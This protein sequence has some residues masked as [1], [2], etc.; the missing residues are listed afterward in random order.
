MS[1]YANTVPVDRTTN[2]GG[3]SDPFVDDH[4]LPIMEPID[5]EDVTLSE[6]TFSP[7]D[8]EDL[9]PSG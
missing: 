1:L 8:I 7:T 4:G 6:K 9:P 5:V 3:D 2:E